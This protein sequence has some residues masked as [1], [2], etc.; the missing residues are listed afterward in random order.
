MDTTL[1]LTV[2]GADRPGI[3]D[4]L[5]ALV[6]GRGGSWQR[7]RMARLAGQFAG[8][9]EVAVPAGERAGL[10]ADLAGLA[11]QGL[12]VHVAESAAVEAPAEGPRRLGIRVLGHDRP[13]IV[14][15]IAAALAADGAN[16]VELESRCAPAPM[17]GVRMF[18]ATAVVELPVGLEPEDL[19]GRLEALAGDMMVDL[20][21]EDA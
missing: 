1:V 16:V 21:I 2:I 13:G 7:S 4:A 11:A 17:T 9:L 18:E 3:V 5:S 8:V 19:R 15:R 12:T 6:A 10:R 20:G 14:R